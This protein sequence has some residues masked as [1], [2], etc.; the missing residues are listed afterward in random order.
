[1]FRSGP[2][3]L[4]SLRGIEGDLYL[5]LQQTA[6]PNRC[7]TAR[8]TIFQDENKIKTMFETLFEFSIQFPHNIFMR[9]AERNACIMFLC[10]GEGRLTSESLWSALP[11]LSCSFTCIFPSSLWKY[12]MSVGWLSEAHLP[13]HPSYA[14]LYPLS[15]CRLSEGGIPNHAPLISILD[16][17]TPSS[18][19]LCWVEP[20][21]TFTSCRTCIARALLL[22]GAE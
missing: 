17:C 5:P 10:D 4:T 16:F 12:Y 15:R 20:L 19:A 2:A 11:R 7:C 6:R 3:S 1:M 22:R 14:G 18:A 8:S 9:V 13:P 21:L